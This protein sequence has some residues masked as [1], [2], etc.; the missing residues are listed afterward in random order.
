MKAFFA[1][2]G[3]DDIYAQEDYPKEEV[4]NSFGV[5]DHFLFDYAFNKIN[6]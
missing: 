3:Y 5:S 2:N 4:V 1:T 6:N